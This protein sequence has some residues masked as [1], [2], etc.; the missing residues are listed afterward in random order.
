MS[1]EKLPEDFVTSL[2]MQEDFFGSKEFEMHRRELLAKL[3]EAGQREKK[4]RKWTMAAALGCGLFFAVLYALAASL[5]KHAENLPEGLVVAVALAV[6][7]SPV[8]VLILVGVYFFR[9]RLVLLRRRKEAR[10]QTLQELPRQLNELRK[11]IEQLRQQLGEK[12]QSGFTLTEM[13]VTIGVLGILTSLLF[14]ALSGAQTKAR[15]TT[16]A[17]HLRQQGLALAMYE[18]EYR[19]YPGCGEPVKL[20]SQAPWGYRRNDSWTALISPYLGDSPKVFNCP[21]YKP[22]YWEAL[23]VYADSYGYNAGGSASLNDRTSTLGLGYDQ[24]NYVSIAT[25][26]SP[27]DM[28]ALGDLQLPTSV[29]AN[30]ISPW[31]ER[32]MGDVDCFVPKRHSGG[33]NMSFADTHVEWRK[34][35][36]WIDEKPVVRARWNID[37]Q[38]HPESWRR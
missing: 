3:E 13:L 14:P 36:Q 35:A 6:I 24:T 22:P 4:A 28:I 19:Y 26:K 8:T 16:C 7:L 33:A 1:R 37:N 27:S 25:V 23:G 9:Y 11:D 5:V 12:K 34:R 38:P 29:A 21:G 10:D 18:G 17:N 15:K 20:L 31:H 2:L 30:Y 32:L